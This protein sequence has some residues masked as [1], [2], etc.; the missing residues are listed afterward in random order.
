MANPL[1]ILAGVADGLEKTTKT[2]IDIQMAKHKLKQ[3]DELLGLKKKAIEQDA[4]LLPYQKEKL[5]EEIGSSKSRIAY[6][7]ALSK[8]KEEEATQKKNNLE[9]II[10]PFMNKATGKLEVPEGYNLDLGGGMGISRSSPRKA[11][12]LGD[13][14][15]EEAPAPEEPKEP[16]LFDELNE[17]ETPKTIRVKRKSDGIMGTINEDE[18]TDEY[19]RI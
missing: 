4:E 3:E 12:G 10:A 2:L 19:E 17:N 6:Y 11:G 15:S 7:S 5:I 9:M 18:L 8:Q 14:L 1:A 16:T 13:V